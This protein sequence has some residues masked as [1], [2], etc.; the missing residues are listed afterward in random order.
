[1]VIDRLINAIVDEIKNKMSVVIEASGRHVH[2]SQDDADR[3]FGKGYNFTV[4][5]ELSQ[6]GQFAYAERVDIAGPKGTIKNVAILGPCRKSTQV[7]VSQT[8]ARILGIN[9][10]VRLSGDIKDTPGCT[11]TNG[12]KTIRVDEGVIVAR[13]HIHIT[14]EDAQRFNVKDNDILKI[15]VFAKRPL[16]FD[17]IC[18][19]ISKDFSTAVHID[20]DE[21]NACG[22]TADTVG[23]IVK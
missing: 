19:R 23:I 3:L 22:F 17:D 9:A 14:P 20:Y 4:K 6:P 5:K 13:R 16:I 15:K 10:P 7:E 1:M 12:D 8:D 2:L 21:A 18:A 11:I